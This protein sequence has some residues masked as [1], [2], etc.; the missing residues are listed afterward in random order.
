MIRKQGK[1]GQSGPS[2]DRWT[3][4]HSAK[5][6]GRVFEVIESEMPPERKAV[7]QEVQEV[8]NWLSHVL[9]ENDKGRNRPPTTE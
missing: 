8:S 9:F 4:P 5:I 6:W 7:R 2:G 1:G 3:D